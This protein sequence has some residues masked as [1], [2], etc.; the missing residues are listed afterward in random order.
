M[1]TPPILVRTEPPQQSIGGTPRVATVPQ[2]PPAQPWD[3]VIRAVNDIKTSQQQVAAR[4]EER[5][6]SMKKELTEQ[7]DRLEK[8]KSGKDY[9]FKRKS[10]EAQHD[11][12]KEVVEKMDAVV[13]L[14]ETMA[15]AGP[16][17]SGSGDDSAEPELS[18]N[19]DKAKR[20]LK[21]GKELVGRR[22]KLLK[23]ADRSEAGWKV[24]EEYM[25]DPVADDSD[26]EK[27][28]RDAERT[29]ERKIAKEKK[30][31][32]GRGNFRGPRQQYYPGFVQ[33]AVTPSTQSL[34]PSGGPVGRG[35]GT[36]R[37]TGPCFA[38]GQ[39]G[40]IRQNCPYPA[41]STWRQ[42]SAMGLQRPGGGAPAAG[43]PGQ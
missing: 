37:R 29:V 23:I 16:S 9:Q 33:S 21:E 7:R 28:I 8:L 1:A 38:C 3:I 25:K 19:L 42:P 14:V 4:M 11:F 15:A 41:A 35:G 31:K 18:T 43:R 6:A 12:N 27:R 40:H 20:A 17:T 10:Y 32:R 39:E 34:W 22:Q 30:G 24:A 13:Q 26:D 36:P 2:A 5:M